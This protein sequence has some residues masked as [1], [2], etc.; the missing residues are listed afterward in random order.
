M[1][2]TFEEKEENFINPILSALHDKMQI[3]QVFTDTSLIL[4]FPGL[5][6]QPY[7]HSVILEER[8]VALSH[9]EFAT[10]LFL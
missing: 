2:L 6:I 5:T 10:L 4:S 7:Q 8:E 3:T 9:L 1:I